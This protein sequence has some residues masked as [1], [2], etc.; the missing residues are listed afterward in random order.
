MIDHDRNYVD[1]TKLTLDWVKRLE[2]EKRLLGDKYNG[3]YK[4]DKLLKEIDGSQF[5]DLYIS[6]LSKNLR[7][8]VKPY[9]KKYLELTKKD[10]EAKSG[11][12]NSVRNSDYYGNK[13]D[14]MKHIHQWPTLVSGAVGAQLGGYVGGLGG[15]AVG[16]M[17]KYGYSKKIFNTMTNKQ[18][19]DELIRLGRIPKTEKQHLTKELNSNPV[20]KTEL[21]NILF[22]KDDKKNN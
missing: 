4:L 20:L 8:N 3:D 21:I 7:E 22:K 19:V 11:L 18:F 17:A 13:Y 12:T 10:K 5:S 2:T 14:I 15:A 6:G 16:G 1:N 9:G